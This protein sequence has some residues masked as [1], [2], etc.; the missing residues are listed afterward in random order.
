MAD[1]IQSVELDAINVML[2]AIG[3]TPTTGDIITAESSAAVVMA[4]RILY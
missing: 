1:P 4:K 2:S 3:E